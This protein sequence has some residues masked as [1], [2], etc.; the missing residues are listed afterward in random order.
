MFNKKETPE[1]KSGEVLN[2]LSKII[3]TTFASFD[4]PVRLVDAI[5]GLR[6]YHFHIQPQKATRMKAMSAF[7]DDLRYAL[8]NNHVEIQAPI[9][10]KK[11][12]GIIVPKQGPFPDI[13][14]SEAITSSEF[15]ESSSLVVP[16][17]VD[18]FGDK[19]LVN[20]ARTPHLLIAGATG[21]GKSCILHSFIG[22][23]IVKNS[24][25]EVRFILCDPRRVDM[26]LYA[27]LPHLLTPPITA[28]KKGVQALA[29]A[30]KEMERRYDILEAESKQNITAYHK[31]V[32]QP[33]KDQWVKAGSKEA[34]SVHLPEALPFIVIIIDEINDF[35]AAYPREF[36]T[37][38]IRLAQMSRAVGIHLIITTQRPSVNVITGSMKANLPSRIALAVASQVD[39]RTIIDQTGAEKLTGEGD[40]LYQGC[41][42]PRPFRIQGYF[43]SETQTKEQV[44][45]WKERDRYS[46]EILDLE[47]TND[48]D[49]DRIFSAMTS[50]S[51][52]EDELY[53]DAKQAVQEA[54]KASTSYLQ[55]K[56]RIGYSRAAR[57]IDL[58]E[59][60]G[61]I[62][63]ADGSKAREVK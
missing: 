22:S 51:E 7:T 32:Y 1:S 46:L 13:P 37:P 35:M 45:I 34:D 28:A 48:S 63:P 29:W 3:I 44:D 55:R 10:D 23:L 49:D 42:E 26:T 31:H 17:G 14:W 15:T 8:E 25:Q 41:D 24:P 53:Q 50:D 27:G 12:V 20:L 16:L 52:A 11:L 56:L 4:V 58:L 6:N 38:I 19:H 62:G 36:E 33:A 47:H 54:G 9:P 21:S 5:D 30:V 60:T 40:M 59:E 39:S 43:I 18:E 57:L 61:V 2:T